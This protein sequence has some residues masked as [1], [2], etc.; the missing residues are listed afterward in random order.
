MFALYNQ[1]K[2]LTFKKGLKLIFFHPYVIIAILLLGG[3]SLRNY[4]DNSSQKEQNIQDQKNYARYLGLTKYLREYKRKGM[5]FFKTGRYDSAVLYFRKSDK[6]SYND[7]TQFFL[8]S[9]LDELDST[10]LALKIMKN[11]E[12]KGFLMGDSIYRHLSRLYFDI[13][14]YRKSIRFADSG[15]RVKD[16]AFFHNIKALN[17]LE[18]AINP[19]LSLSNRQKGLDSASFESLRAYK[20]KPSN[21][22]KSNFKLIQYYEGNQVN[23]KQVIDS[24]LHVDSTKLTQQHCSALLANISIRENDYPEAE[25]YLTIC[26]EMNPK[27]EN[28]YFIRAICYIHTN[29]IDR[30]CLDFNKA[31]LL[32]NVYAK[33]SLLKYGLRSFKVSN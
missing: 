6:K 24:I 1:L 32:G 29:S 4:F 8:G 5:K 2:N 14:K 30:A 15:L 31:R 22:Y 33:D 12:R 11:L 7:S 13:G 20:L 21:R 25:K 16:D 27:D 17:L 23:S 9:A 10:N 19:N 28:N 3:V 18:L 26:I